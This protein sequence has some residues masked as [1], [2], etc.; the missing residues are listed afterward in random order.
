MRL[1]PVLAAMLLLSGLASAREPFPCLPWAVLA[2]QPDFAMAL[3]R[4]RELWGALDAM[5]LADR[6]PGGRGDRLKRRLAREGGALGAEARCLQLRS[7]SEG[8]LGQRSWETLGPLRLSGQM[9]A[10]LFSAPTAPR[11][12]QILRLPDVGGWR[13]TARALAR[14]YFEGLPPEPSDAWPAPA[15]LRR[16]KGRWPDLVDSWAA[17]PQGPER[18]ALDLAM[19]EEARPEMPHTD[20]LRGRAVHLL[21]PTQG[22]LR[23]LGDAILAYLRLAAREVPWRLRVTASASSASPLYP[24]GPVQGR[25][26]RIQVNIAP[27]PG[28][29]APGSSPAAALVHL[30]GEPATAASELGFGPALDDELQAHLR[31]L[32][33]G[34]PAP[35]VLLGSGT[36]ALDRWRTAFARAGWPAEAILQVPIEPGATDLGPAARRAKA[37][38]PELLVLVIAHGESDRLLRYLSSAGVWA[39]RPGKKVRP[40]ELHPWILAPASFAFDPE[41]QRRNRDYLDGVRVAPDLPPIDRWQALPA[42]ATYMERYRAYPPVLALR[43]AAL[44]SRLDTVRNVDPAGLQARMPGRTPFGTLRADGAHLSLRAHAQVFRHGA[45]V[46]LPNASPP[47]N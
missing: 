24:T 11:L 33:P 41:L 22:R 4:L 32:P 7:P 39:R 25:G 20:P 47:E 19:G 5:A 16:A 35:V 1:I 12:A 44:L 38:H 21:L 14:R 15:A 31:A 28:H 27:G 37:L 2:V 9:V 26:A 8:P 17:T 36:V 18:R 40:G 13:P 10:A 42:V 34:T 6:A 29:E 46:A 30:G 3:P 23:S 45:F 43:L